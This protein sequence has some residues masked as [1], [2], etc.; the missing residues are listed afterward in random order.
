MSATA[1]LRVRDLRVHYTRGKVTVRAV[2]G[3]DMEIGR[4]R[5]LGLVGESGCGKSTLGKAVVRLIKPTG[6]SVEFDG[7]D[8]AQLDERGLR[9][10][11]PRIQMIFQD[12]YSSLNPRIDVHDWVEEPLTIHSRGS[13]AERAVRVRELL[14]RVGLSRAAERRYPSQLSGGQRQRVGIARALALDPDLL[15]ADEPTSA[16]D[17][18]IQAQVLALLAQIQREFG[19]TYL[20][21]SH[22]LG[23]V[24]HLAEEIAVMYLG[25]MCEVGPARRVLDQPA[26][27][28]TVALLSAA[29]VPDPAVEAVRERIV[30][31]GD[32]PSP[33]DPPSG[34]RFH[35]RCWLRGS[36]GDPEICVTTDPPAVTA[37]GGGSV[38]CHFHDR[39]AVTHQVRSVPTAPPPP[40]PGGAA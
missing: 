10:W 8:L 29:P 2:D 30:L 39:V 14:E 7:C 15:V 37:P 5:T 4:G 35:T 31:R 3:V 40:S 12:P 26:H 17:V 22:D 36:I 16:L 27:P 28:Y 19:L 18:S 1:L 32:P 20:F 21:I 33:A 23:A 38:H 9:P 13:R 24:R 6:G 25:R 11:R 34:C